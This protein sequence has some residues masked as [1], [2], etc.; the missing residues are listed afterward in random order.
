MDTGEPL[1]LKK[2]SLEGPVA[3]RILG[4]K[5]KKR[6]AFSPFA[7]DRGMWQLRDMKPRPQDGSLFTDSASFPFV[8]F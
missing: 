4:Y 3:V 6:G 5:Y 2:E 1:K 7:G 8:S